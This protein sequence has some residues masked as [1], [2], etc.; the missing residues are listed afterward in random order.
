MVG[1]IVT[2]QELWKAIIEGNAG[3]TEREFLQSEINTFLT[4]EK[5][6]LM[7]CGREYYEG[8]QDILNKQRIVY[9]EYGNGKV[10]TN[11]PNNRIVNNRFDD[12][13]D[14]KVNYLLAKD[15][16]IKGIEE[17]DEIFTA[18]WQRKIKYV[19]LDS[20]VGGVG[21][22]HPYIDEQGVL[23]FK[24]M[25]PEQIIPF[26]HDEEHEVLDAFIYMYDVEVYDRLS[27]KRTIKKIE[28]YTPMGISYYEYESYNLRP[29]KSRDNVNHLTISG[30]G[31]NW[32]RIPLIA[33][34]MNS[35]EQPLIVRVKSLQDALNSLISNYADCMEEDIRSTILVIK[36][37]DG[38]DLGTFRQNLAQYG[39]IKVRAIEGVQGGVD[40]LKIDVN[41]SNYEVILKL[42][43]DAIVE[44]GRGFDAKDDRMS[45]N[46][47][48]MNIH[49]MYSDIDLDANEME[50]EFKAA[51]EQMMWFINTYRRIIRASELTD[52]EFIFNRDLP[53]NEGDVIT[54]CRN[55]VGIISNETIIANHP[56]TRNTEEEL[57]RLKAEQ[58]EQMTLAMGMDY[59][60]QDTGG[61]D[62]S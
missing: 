60:T 33:F 38:T 32:E 14:Q 59:V 40:A 5:Y 23:Q 62:E 37:Y 42:L 9:D 51:F 39:A 56:W 47:N 48:Q 53:M 19:A 2:L 55:S 4:S 17:S 46:P 18:G 6:K 24:R 57:S 36:N 3:I 22:L 45:N 12:L 58:L 20:L 7:K 21:Y 34:R 29:D 26:W 1:D 49:S 8:K 44:N 27:S 15:L 41:A 61:G 16:E 31:F 11:F 35:I 28:Y 52:V 13:V 30:E 50:L 43:K 10:M 25:K 54:N